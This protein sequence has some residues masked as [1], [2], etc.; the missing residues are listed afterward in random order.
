MLDKAR[1]SKKLTSIVKNPKHTQ[2]EETTGKI[3][4]EKTAVLANRSGQVQQHGRHSKEEKP[5]TGSGQ[6]IHVANFHLTAVTTFSALKIVM[7]DFSTC[8][9][10]CRKCKMTIFGT[11]AIVRSPLDLFLQVSRASTD[12]QLLKMSHCTCSTEQ[13][14]PS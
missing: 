14:S 6:V 8:A 7:F 13:I 1:E 10:R 3:I 2:R 4:N 11:D 9:T 12:G 5:P